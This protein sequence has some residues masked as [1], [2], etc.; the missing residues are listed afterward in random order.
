MAEV[1]LCLDLG[2]PA[3][4]ICF[5]MLSAVN[6]MR[7]VRILVILTLAIAALVE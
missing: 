2:W 6:V 4:M 7:P 1:R 3:I 5:R